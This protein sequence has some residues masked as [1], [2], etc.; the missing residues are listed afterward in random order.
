[1]AV[2]GGCVKHVPGLIADWKMKRFVAFSVALRFLIVER[3]NAAQSPA[4]A[5]SAG[6]AAP[7]QNLDRG[8]SEIA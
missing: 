7:A 3:A 6:Q 2:S 8:W 1:M 4:P 5:A